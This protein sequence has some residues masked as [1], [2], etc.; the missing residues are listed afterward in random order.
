MK[1]SD[2]KTL[3]FSIMS[4]PEACIVTQIENISK[5]QI[6]INLMFQIVNLKDTKQLFELATNFSKALE[7]F[8]LLA[9]LR[10]QNMGLPA[11]ATQ[12]IMQSFIKLTKLSY[13]GNE[14]SFSRRYYGFC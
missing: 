12:P 3:C 11:T 7:K 1:F 9:S 10:L 8:P 5:L 2:L 4:V 6:L 13:L 14:W